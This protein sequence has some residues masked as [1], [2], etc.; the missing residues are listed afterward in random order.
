MSS[1][2]YLERGLRRKYH[3]GLVLAHGRLRIGRHALLKEVVLALQGNAL[4]EGERIGR[5]IRLGVAQLEEQTIRHEFNVLAH[6][7][8]IHA[9]ELARQGLGDEL[10]L[11]LHGLADNLVSLLLAQLVRQLGVQE[12]GK[13]RV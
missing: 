12:A 4:H 10:L 3:L 11:N 9:N 2:A 7:L 8:R 1:G 13:V 5:R 6:E